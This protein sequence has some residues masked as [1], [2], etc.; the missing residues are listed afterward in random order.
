MFKLPEAG[1][2][3]LKHTAHTVH[4]AHTLHTS[5]LSLCLSLA[6][7]SSYSPTPFIE[8]Q[9]ISFQC[10][11]TGPRAIL[12]TFP[13]GGALGG[14]RLIT[15][16]I[17]H[18]H[19]SPMSGPHYTLGAT[20]LQVCWLLLSIGTVIHIQPNYT[21]HIFLATNMMFSSLCTFAL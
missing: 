20:M 21:N 18:V 10:F 8:V 14:Q 11:V 2:M 6:L 15:F 3:R 17:K 9:P 19:Y 5:S 4:K 1:K 16:Y 12:F 7:H 13:S